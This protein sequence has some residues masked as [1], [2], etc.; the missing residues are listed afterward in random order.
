VSLFG[1]TVELQLGTE[2]DSGRAFRGLRCRFDVTMTDTKTPNSAKIELYNAAPETIAL[3]QQTDAVVRLLVGYGAEPRLIFH[4]D[5]IPDGVTVRRERV[6]RI[7][8]IE[9]QDGRRA[10][11]GTHVDV[12][13]ATEQ[14]GRQVFSVVADELGLPLGV[15]D[16]GDD[17]RFPS[18]LALSGPAR[19]VL[20]RLAAM[21]G[22]RWTIRDGTLQVWARG[23]TTGEEAILFSPRT[24]LIGSPVRT[25]KG[26]VEL[27][28]LIAPSL[29][30]GRPFRLESELV[31][32]DY[33]AREVQFK[34]DNGFERDFYVH[35]VGVP[36]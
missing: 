15:T 22:R 29:R 23:G 34:G 18:G 11:T 32:G 30:P 35:V 28:A 7:L 16:L 14:T 1:R 36:R 2:G 13:F 27:M 4:G 10:Y 3:A 9:A 31:S 21:T 6:D 26:G 25:D 20:E 17:V 33:V 24:G 5:P 12:S 8:A 19:D